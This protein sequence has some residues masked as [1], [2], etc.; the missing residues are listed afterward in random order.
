M[1]RVKDERSFDEHMNKLRATGTLCDAVVI[2]N[3]DTN[4]TKRHFDVHRCV[5]TLVPYFEQTFCGA[6]LQTTRV[7]LSETSAVTASSFEQILDYV[8]TGVMTLTE[9]N[10]LAIAQA[11]DFFCI[12]YLRKECERELCT[13]F[14][15]E[16][17]VHNVWRMA[18]EL[19]MA[20]VVERAERIVCRR[21]DRLPERD[22]LDVVGLMQLFRDGR[23]WSRSESDLFDHV[24]RLPEADTLRPYVRHQKMLNQSDGVLLVSDIKACTLVVRD[25]LTGHERALRSYWKSSN[26]ET[27]KSMVAGASKVFTFHQNK[28]H[29]LDIDEDRW[30]VGVAQPSG[31]EGAMTVVDHA[32]VYLLSGRNYKSI[33]FECYDVQ[34]NVWRS[35]SH[36]IANMDTINV[37]LITFNKSV[38]ALGEQRFCYDIAS[39]RWSCA[40]K[41]Q[42]A[43]VEHY[44]NR[45]LTV[46]YSTLYPE[47]LCSLITERETAVNDQQK[48]FDHKNNCRDTPFGKLETWRVSAC[49][50]GVY[51]HFFCWVQMTGTQTPRLITLRIVLCCY[52]SNVRTLTKT[53]AFRRPYLHGLM[54]SNYEL[55]LPTRL[56]CV[57]DQLMLSLPDNSLNEHTLGSIVY[58]FDITRNE[59]R[60]AFDEEE[61]VTTRN[62]N[63]RTMVVPL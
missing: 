25:L 32:Y 56:A 3:D 14:M 35:L 46:D 42:C 61:S 59:W 16:K 38:Y 40:D 49:D 22:E 12:D 41:N 45:P 39:D 28:F 63:I 33:H 4:N 55:Y 44:W 15:S 58:T 18:L 36:P 31:Y 53:V 11:A 29:I 10:V 26:G 24:S 6:F 20:K 57:G 21:F 27:P 1:F 30:L 2:C 19:S 37:S 60:N 8:Y 7:D 13:K 51:K 9:E 23:I 5:L 17:N 34:K 47:M 62:V 54:S 48:E 52:A 43:I 50:Y